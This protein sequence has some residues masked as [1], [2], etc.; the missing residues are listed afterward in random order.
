MVACGSEHSSQGPAGLGD[1][2]SGDG[3]MI[4]P[5]VVG[6]EMDGG[7]NDGGGADLISFA[8]I[9]AEFF[10]P[11]QC[12]RCH[13]EYNDYGNVVANITRGGF[14]SIPERIVTE[15]S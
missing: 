4:V 15:D 3:G 11:N 14:D 7:M 5:V 10:Q 2:D 12:L 13:A 6:D 8:Q 9:T 1:L